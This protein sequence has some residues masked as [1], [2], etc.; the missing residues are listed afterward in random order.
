MTDKPRFQALG[1]LRCFQQVSTDGS[2]VCGRPA[3]FKRL[4]RQQ[5]VTPVYCDEHALASDAP[6]AGEVLTRRVSFT[7]QVDF[8]GAHVLESLARGDAYAALER[9]IQAAG[10]QLSIVAANV[11]L[12]R[13]DAPRPP[14]RDGHG[15]GIGRGRPLRQ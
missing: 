1:P 11:T 14:R 15:G 13:Y 9:A 10:G 6:I 2:G 3:R 4:G 12:G 7:V 8:A 5:S